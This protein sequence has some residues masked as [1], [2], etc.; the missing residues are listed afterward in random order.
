MNPGDIYE[1]RDGGPGAIRIVGIDEATGAIIITGM[2]FGPVYGV[3]RVSLARHYQRKQAAAPAPAD[4]ATPI[5]EVI[6]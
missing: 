2:E 6:A 5:E 3:D 4:W 1:R